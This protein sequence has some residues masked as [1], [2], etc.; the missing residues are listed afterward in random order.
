MPDPAP[1]LDVE[2]LYCDHNGWLQG[3]L[4][5]RLGNSFDAADLAHDTFVRVLAKDLAAVMREPRAMLTTIA[6][7]MVVSLHRRRKIEQAYL[8]ALATLPEPLLPP[9]DTRAIML[10]TLIDID[11]RLDRL[12][13]IVRKAFLLARLDGL[14][15]ADIAAQLGVSIPTVKRYIARAVERC[16]FLD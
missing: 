15:Q 11:A 9:E 5:R 3:W 13:A 8:D 14:E 1:T 16:Y 10:E 12:P 4:R 6:H 2:T 7:G